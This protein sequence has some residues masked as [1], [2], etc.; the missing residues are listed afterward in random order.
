MFDQI[1]SKIKYKVLVLADTNKRATIAIMR[2]LSK[3]KIQFCAA[4]KSCDKFKFNFLSLCSIGL[5]HDDVFYY[6]DDE[7]KSLIDSLVGISRN[8]GPLVIFPTGE[9][10][11][12]WILED[13]K[14][15]NS[16]N[17]LI[18]MVEQKI[19]EEMSNKESFLKLAKKV[20]LAIPKECV[21]IPIRYDKPFV[22]KPKHAC[23]G[24][25]GV[26]ENPFLVETKRSY[27]HLFDQNINTRKHIIQQYINGPSYY[28]CSIYQD[29]CKKAF[30]IQQT[31][32]Q[33]PAGKSVI[34]AAPSS[35][36]IEIVQK[37]DKLMR[38]LRWE[39]VMMLELKCMNNTYYAIE[40]NPR[41]WGPLQLAIDNGVDFPAMLYRLALG[42][43]LFNIDH[44]NVQYGYTW[45]N[46][47]VHGFIV[48]IKTGNKFQIHTDTGNRIKYRDVWWRKDSYIYG[49][50]DFIKSLGIVSLLKRIKSALKLGKS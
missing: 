46:G 30:F 35:L 25:Q 26:L 2:S 1:D 50:L 41:F 17:I 22:V 24:E 19:Y 45:L 7:K 13:R 47:F 33:E 18:P 39:G 9:K 23:W 34:V 5:S 6:L 32:V 12:R 14:H 21:G 49:I 15:L 3:N 27:A 4:F 20:G 36:P 48:R 31:I 44:P 10:Y 28:Y 43:S 40:C 37:I 38:L 29:G 11:L 42:K 16:N 8:T